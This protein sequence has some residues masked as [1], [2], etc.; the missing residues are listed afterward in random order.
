MDH[1]R[2]LP[3]F[4][5]VSYTQGSGTSFAQFKHD[6]KN[7]IRFTCVAFKVYSATLSTTMTS[8]RRLLS[9]RSWAALA[10]TE[11]RWQDRARP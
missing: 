8:S 10:I 6:K 5:T 4:G 1:D 7:F 2:S 3:V 9:K 11:P